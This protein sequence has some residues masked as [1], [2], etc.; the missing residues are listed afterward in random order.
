MEFLQ[1]IKVCFTLSNSLHLQM[2]LF[3]FFQDPDVL[4]VFI[5]LV[6]FLYNYT[7]SSA[8]TAIADKTSDDNDPFQQMQNAGASLIQS[9]DRKIFV[10]SFDLWNTLSLDEYRNRPL[11]LSFLKQILGILCKQTRIAGPVQATWLRVR[12]DY[13]FGRLCVS[14]SFNFSF[15]V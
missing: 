8:P 5:G 4:S 7:L 13:A 11:D 1:G 10:E 2:P 9:I 3:A 12:A 14:F 15:S 6:A